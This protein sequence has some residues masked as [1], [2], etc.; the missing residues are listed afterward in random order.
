MKKTTSNLIVAFVLLVGIAPTTVVSAG[1]FEFV[2]LGDTAYCPEV[3]TPRYER[4]IDMI[5]AASPAF[6]I[7]V[8]D[9]GKTDKGACDEEVRQTARRQFNSFDQPL[10]YSPGDNEWADCVYDADPLQQLDRLRAMFFSES[11]SLGAQTLPVIRQSDESEFKEFVENLR[12]EWNDVLFSTVH[13]VGSHNGLD[14]GIGGAKV[15]ASDAALA[16]YQ[17]RNSAN[18]EWIK[19]TFDVAN[20]RGSK[21]VVVV[22]H[23]DIYQA[24]AASSPAFR[25]IK[26]ALA[27]H[28]KSFLGQV[29]FINGDSHKFL[30]D[31]PLITF[32]GPGNAQTHMNVTRLVVYGDPNVRAVTVTVDTDTPWVFGF[33]P[34]FETGEGR[35]SAE[36][37]ICDGVN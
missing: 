26:Q 5:N 34:L 3:D 14:P 1:S 18:I 4:L 29:L 31:K 9:I 30:I 32:S 16:E 11:T 24:A 7:H 8:G 10:I 15:L 23:A 28:T 22:F 21:A 35:S 6:S 20:Q 17:T 2:A 36:Q 33:Q 13:V 27:E 25:G 19:R 12:W 37:K